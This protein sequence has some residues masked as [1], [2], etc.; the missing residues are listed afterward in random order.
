M[1][2]P[3]LWSFA[4]WACSRSDAGLQMSSLPRCPPSSGPQPTAAS[5]PGEFLRDFWFLR[6]HPGVENRLVMVKLYDDTRKPIPRRSRG[7][8]MAGRRGAWRQSCKTKPIPAGPGGTSPGG[9]GTWGKCAE[10]TQFGRRCRAILPR[11]STHRPRPLPSRMCETKPICTG[12][13]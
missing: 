8:S 7:G 1:S 6:Q 10:R 2:L 4:F 13:M 11:P 5:L 9:H 3:G 12:A